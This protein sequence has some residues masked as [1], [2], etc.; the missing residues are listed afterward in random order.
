MRAWISN[1]WAVIW[2]KRRHVLLFF[3][4]LVGGLFIGHALEHASALTSARYWLYGYQMRLQSRAPAA[5]HQTAVILLEDSDYWSQS[6]A[7]RSP[8]NRAQ[9]AHLLDIL[10]EDGV[11]T[12]ALDLDLRSPLSGCPG[13]D[14]SAYHDEDQ[15]LDTSIKQLCHHGNW[16]VVGTSIRFQDGQYS[17]VPSLYSWE[18]DHGPAADYSCLLP[19][20]LQLPHDLRLF[21]GSLTLGT[22]Q[23][24]DSFSMAAVRTLDNAR[25]QRAAQPPD[26]GFLFS[27]YL[28]EADYGPDTGPF[29]FSAGALEKLHQTD[30]KAVRRLLASRVVLIGGA[31]HTTAAGQGPRVDL[32]DSPTG[33]IPGVFLHANYIEALNGENGTFA[34]LSDS[35]IRVVEIS[36][37]VALFWVGL[38]EIHSGWKYLAFSTSLLISFALTYILLQNL[39]IFMDFLVPLCIL[40]LHTVVEEIINWRREL[41]KFRLIHATEAHHAAKPA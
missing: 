41:H 9:I 4:L 21:P 26:R 10:R 5:P 12:I 13:C 15:A 19:G 31:W 20:Y 30:P 29:L 35:V 8:V 7:G 24:L 17:E 2:H 3:G 36:L 28:S 40:V 39:G 16:L 22:G 1:Q 23:A 27:R 25:Y 11:Q 34:P 33:P 18:K 37:A 14:F 38:Q 32:Y 6:Y